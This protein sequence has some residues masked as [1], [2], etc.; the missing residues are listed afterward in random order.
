MLQFKRYAINNPQLKPWVNFIWYFETTTKITINNKLLPTV[1]VDIIL[2]PY[3]KIEYFI[4]GKCTEAGAIHFN[5]MRNKHRVILQEGVLKV[6]G[7]SFFSY[8]LYPFIHTPMSAFNTR[9]VDLK[10]CNSRLEERLTAA[11]ELVPEGSAMEMV[12][13]FEQALETELDLRGLN[14]DHIQLIKEF[15]QNN[16]EKSIN[17]FCQQH[18]ISVKTFER[19]C[20]KYTGYNPKVLQRIG[21]FQAASNQ[22]IFE[23]EDRS[24]SELAYLHDYYDQSHFIREFQSHTGVSPAEFV[25]EGKTIK[26]NA[27]LI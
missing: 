3:S 23:E 24:F 13:K 1:S 9:I 6:F 16:Y 27:E 12:E 20:S 26:E 22:L 10:E 18:K 2:S 4:E 19:A 5:G 15:S 14:L 17:Q 25:Q 11:L 8:G 21:R 7:I